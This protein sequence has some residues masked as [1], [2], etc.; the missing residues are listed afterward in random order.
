MRKLEGHHFKKQTLKLL[1]SVN[2]DVTP[3]SPVHFLLMSN[4]QTNGYAEKGET[5][6]TVSFSLP[7]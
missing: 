1:W 7:G 3:V 5:T 6:F 4:T 2:S